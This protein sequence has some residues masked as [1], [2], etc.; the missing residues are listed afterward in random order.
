MITWGEWL[1]TAARV[2]V[3]RPTGTAVVSDLHLGY[4]EARLLRGLACPPPPVEETLALL[5]AGLRVH[6]LHAL[7]VAGD[8][9]EAGPDAETVE[10]L[11]SWVNAAGVR[12]L[13][14]LAG[15][16]DRGLRLVPPSLRP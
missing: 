11:L 10:R 16:H 12:S 8:L 1:L 9:F 5:Q 15:N 4:A 6:A 2:A 7:L 14:V 13:T 3:H